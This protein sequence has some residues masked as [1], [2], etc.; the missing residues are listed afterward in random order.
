MGEHHEENE[1]VYFAFSQCLLINVLILHR[2]RLKIVRITRQS[3]AKCGALS[4]FA[5]LSEDQ[6][7]NSCA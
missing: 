2:F 6:D 5:L 1:I 3:D 4:K 7:R